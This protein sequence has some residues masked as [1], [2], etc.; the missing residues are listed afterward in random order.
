MKN[1]LGML[2]FNLALLTLN[3]DNIK[4]LQQIK[5]LDIFSPSSTNFHPDGLF[6]IEIF[7]KVGDERRNRLFAYI[8]MGIEVFHPLIYKE[9]CALKELYGKIIAGT[10]YAVFDHQLK[11]FVAASPVDGRTGYTF[12]LEYFDKLQFEERPSTSREFA[13]KLI[14]KNRGSLLMRYLVVLPAGL[15]DFTIEPNGKREE[16]EINT[17]YRQILS[18]GNVMLGSSGVKDKSHL[19]TS[20]AR[21]QASVYELYQYII[22][23]LQG[24]SKLIQGHWTSRNV[25]NSTRNVI[26]A[27]VSKTEEL[28]DI[29][30]VTTNDEVAGLYQYCRS[31]FP[32]FTKFVRDYA[33]NV[34]SGPNTPARLINRKTL[35]QEAVSVDPLYYDEWMTQ[36]GIESLLNMFESEPLRDLE[37][38]VS[39]YYFGLIYR[40]G[41]FVKLVSDISE[42]PDH[43]DKKLVRPITYSELFYLAVY[44][45]AKRSYCL[46]CRYPIINLGGVYPASVYLK[47]TTKSEIL[48]LLDEEWKP[49]GKV[50][51]EFPVM[52]VSYFNSIAPSSTHTK[53]AGADFDGDTM[54]FIV[55]LTEDSTNEIKK[56]LES[57]DYYVGVNG[58]INYS[59]SDGVSDLVFLELSS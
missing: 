55:L 35:Q 28:F 24:D 50:F 53:K 49:S 42:V 17:L 30:S 37:I 6:S 29:R 3:A 19:D 59:T 58:S 56:T 45:H 10:A 26:T 52:G 48:E 22:N 12:F 47:T 2:P 27:S 13:I 15:R 31:I 40:D 39:G 33:E 7:G 16:D 21:L 18:I 4:G 5:V 20:R 41:K 9:I 25:Y 54:N 38:E 46:T 51:N 23:L 11:D 34:F 14:N 8:D 32:V 57:R 44:D 1:L 43:F 36:E